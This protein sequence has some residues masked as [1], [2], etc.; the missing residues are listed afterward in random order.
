MGTN[1]RRGLMETGLFEIQA[2]HL[3]EFK[4]T[5]QILP[6]SREVVYALFEGADWVI[7]DR[8]PAS[9][10]ITN[11]TEPVPR[12][13][14]NPIGPAIDPAFELARCFLRLANLRNSRSTARAD[15]KQPFGTKLARSRLLSMPWTVASHT[16]ERVISYGPASPSPTPHNH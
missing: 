8:N 15:M 5:R 9:H 6:A 1:D 7:Y 2:S 14:P 13:E 3:R 10:D 11:A 4:Q 12:S 16:R